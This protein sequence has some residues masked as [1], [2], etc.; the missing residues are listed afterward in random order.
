MLYNSVGLGIMFFF[1]AHG[2]W[3]INT[4]FSDGT[5]NEP[6]RDA[7]KNSLAEKLF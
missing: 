7:L 1:V 6:S 5:I 2:S 3:N 4:A